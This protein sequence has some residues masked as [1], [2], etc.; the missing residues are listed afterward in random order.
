[1]YK[2]KLFSISISSY[3]FLKIYFLLLVF[4]HITKWPNLVLHPIN[5]LFI[6]K[7]DL[8]MSHWYHYSEAVLYMTDLTTLYVYI[9]RKCSCCS[10]SMGYW[11]PNVRRENA[12]NICV[13][14]K[15]NYL[16]LKRLSSKNLLF[17]LIY[18]KS[19]YKNQRVQ[20]LKAVFSCWVYNKMSNNV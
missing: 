19:D 4:V 6:L 2:V 5:V 11:W 10:T 14:L 20:L 15:C 13:W 3:M 12:G 8:W 7:K 1:M 16:F 17:V 9:F 18:W